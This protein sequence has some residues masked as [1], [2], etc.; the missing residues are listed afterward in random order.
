MKTQSLRAG[1]LATLALAPMF[2]VSET[3]DYVANSGVV[4]SAQGTSLVS[5]ALGG[6]LIVEGS[7][8]AARRAARKQ[9]SSLSKNSALLQELK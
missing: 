1:R 2:M 4:G 8:R 9:L 3:F 6:G 7:K 5:L